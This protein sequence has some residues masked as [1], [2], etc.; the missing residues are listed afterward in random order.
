MT[1]NP[2]PYEVVSILNREGAMGEPDPDRPESAD[3]LESE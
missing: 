1:A 3:L 2:D